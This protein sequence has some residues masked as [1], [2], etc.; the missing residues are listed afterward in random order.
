M[1]HFVLGE[2]AR[3]EGR[4]DEALARYARAVELGPQLAEAHYQYALALGGTR[5]L[6]EADFHFARAAGLRGDYLGA[7]AGYRR[8]RES[9][10]RTRP[11]RPGSTRRCAT[12][13]SPGA[14]G[15]AGR[16]SRLHRALEQV[17]KAGL[18]SPVDAPPPPP[19]R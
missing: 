19:R 9:S 16:R 2:I 3:S 14:G 12:W 10:G 5:R 15:Q 6:G 18:G 17:V 7:L 4:P 8:A 11:G 13:S 1:A